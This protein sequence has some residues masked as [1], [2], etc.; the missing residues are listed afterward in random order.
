[1]ATSVR[2]D[3]PAVLCTSTKEEL[4]AQKM[5][6]LDVSDDCPICRDDYGILC[7]VAR[8]PSTATGKISPDI[9]ILSSSF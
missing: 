5:N 4:L 3:N 1:M 8:H 6:P 9:I 7:R 2:S